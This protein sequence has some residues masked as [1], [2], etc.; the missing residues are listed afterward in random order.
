LPALVAY[1][2]HR[3]ADHVQE[4]RSGHLGKSRGRLWAT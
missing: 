2:R 1:G 3:R 4:K